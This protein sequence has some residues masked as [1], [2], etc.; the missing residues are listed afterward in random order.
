[1]TPPFQTLE[2]KSIEL[3]RERANQL[4]T[5]IPDPIAT[6]SARDGPPPDAQRAGI[7]GVA[8]RDRQDLNKGPVPSPARIGYNARQ[9]AQR[10][11]GPGARNAPA[12]KPMI[13]YGQQTTARD[14]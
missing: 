4:R 1:M 14:S 13:R 6:G 7:D 2:A 9:G 8:P 11:G 5:A 12:A 10:R 3:G